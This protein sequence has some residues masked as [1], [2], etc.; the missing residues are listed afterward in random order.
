MMLQYNGQTTLWR[1]DDYD[2]VYRFCKRQMIKTIHVVETHFSVA[3]V[4]LLTKRPSRQIPLSM[5]KYGPR[6]YPMNRESVVCS[7][8]NKS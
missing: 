7:I 5:C 8:F 3:H 2:T 1:R 6:R 4:K